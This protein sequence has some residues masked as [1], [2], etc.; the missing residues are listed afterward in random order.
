MYDFNMKILNNL[1]NRY[2][3]NFLAFI[4]LVNFYTF[5]VAVVMLKIS[6]Q[7]DI[8]TEF[9]MYPIWYLAFFSII[10][11]I[12]LF[13]TE[14][15]RITDEKFLNSKIVFFGQ[16]LGVF[17]LF[18]SVAAPLLPLLD[19]LLSPYWSFGDWNIPFTDY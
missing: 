17:C 2:S 3:F 15:N 8:F 6:N 4:G 13:F 7:F 1:R 14:K 12:W 19:P 10:V 5:L 11:A 16:L 9:I 18:L